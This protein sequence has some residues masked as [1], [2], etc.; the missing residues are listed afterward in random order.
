MVHSNDDYENKSG[1]KFTKTS[2]A[3]AAKSDMPARQ[4]SLDTGV[5]PAQRQ[6]AEYYLIND[7]SKRTPAQAPADT[8]VYQHPGSMPAA[9]YAAP[10][11]AQRPPMPKEQHYWP[12]APQPVAAQIPQS[13][14][15]PETLQS[16]FYTAGFLENFI[17]QSIRVEFMLGTSGALVDRSG[18][19]VQVGTSYIVLEPEN[20]DDLLYCD[21]YSIRFVTIYR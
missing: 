17:G 1:F 8:G 5:R 7:A 14:R 6:P 3:Q 11:T 20:T 19:L 2:P 4:R 18:R 16:D 10:I 13:R 9:E 12:F 15:V 21:L